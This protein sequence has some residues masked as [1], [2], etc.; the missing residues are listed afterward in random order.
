MAADAAQHFFSKWDM[1]FL[2]MKNE[3]QVIEFIENNLS[4]IKDLKSRQMGGKK[5]KSNQ[6]MRRCNISKATRNSTLQRGQ[7][8]KTSEGKR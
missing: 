4:H 1:K 8:F 5:V 2:F 6:S 3:I 7:D